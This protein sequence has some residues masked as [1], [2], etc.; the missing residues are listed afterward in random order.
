M[1]HSISFSVALGA[2][3]LFL[4]TGAAAAPV[5]LQNGTAT[6]SQS[7]FGINRVQTVFGTGDTSS[8][9]GTAGNRPGWAIFRSSGTD[10]SLSDAAVWEIAPGGEVG[11]DDGFTDWTFSILS[12]GSAANPHSLG[13]LRILYTTANRSQFALGA[14]DPGDRNNAPGSVGGDP[15]VIGASSIWTQFDL[16]P[17]NASS[18]NINT[19]IAEMAQN[20]LVFTGT[21]QTFERYTVTVRTPAGV[22]GITGIRLETLNG[23]AALPSGGPGRVT[24]T[25]AGN[26]ILRE[27]SVDAVTTQLPPPPPPGVPVP[28]T[29]ALFLVAPLAALM[30]RRRRPNK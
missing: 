17:L 12:G 4:A 26:F 24:G 13:A 3:A 23:V 10:R 5:T 15:T 20:I 21:R 25:A 6:F 14:S 11:T 30:G 9:F 8:A 16:D 7:D 2:A 19:T 22:S 1:T 18:N 28:S 29:A 27:F